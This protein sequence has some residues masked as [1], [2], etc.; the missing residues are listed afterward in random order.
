MMCQ[1]DG[2]LGKG[3][4]HQ[5]WQFEFDHCGPCSRRE[6][7]FKSYS[8]PVHTLLWQENAYAHIYTKK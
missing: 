3:V 8:L 7:T 4:G 5:A 1:Q 6:P 2:S